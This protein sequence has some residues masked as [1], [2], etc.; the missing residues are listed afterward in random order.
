MNRFWESRTM[1]PPTTDTFS[2]ISINTTNIS[3]NMMST[4]SPTPRESRSAEELCLAPEGPTSISTNSF[5]MTSDSSSRCDLD[6]CDNLSVIAPS[7]I[8]HVHHNCPAASPTRNPQHQQVPKPLPSAMERCLSCMSKLGQGGQLSGPDVLRPSWTMDLTSNSSPQEP[9]NCDRLSLSSHG[10]SSGGGV[11][12]YYYDT[13]RSVLVGD[14]RRGA[15]C[16]AHTPPAPLGQNN[17]QMSYHGYGNCPVSPHARPNCESPQ[18]RNESPNGYRLGQCGVS[19][20]VPGTPIYY[21]IPEQLPPQKSSSAVTGSGSS[22]GSI[23]LTPHN[24][25]PYE[26][27]DFPRV[28]P[29]V[30]INPG[31]GLAGQ[32]QSG[33]S[34]GSC[35][36]G[37]C[38]GASHLTNANIDWNKVGFLHTLRR[39]Y[40]CPIIWY[41]TCF[42]GIQYCMNMSKLLDLDTSC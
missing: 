42:C 37:N 19:G 39:K 30:T 36:N 16:R 9:G 35:C 4:N 17:G 11:T 7:Q 6:S 1:S 33:S 5:W 38:N 34:Q 12:E 22:R 28:A 26:N 21:N 32:S 40:K 10:S 24:S 41:M 29:P 23:N 2:N 25:G 3:M 15:T 8:G 18:R 31:S 20:P 14:M 27:Y 13:P